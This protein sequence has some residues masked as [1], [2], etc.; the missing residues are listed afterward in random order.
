MEHH[1]K[2]AAEKLGLQL[3][4]YELKPK[5]GKA[6]VSDVAAAHEILGLPVADYLRCCELRLNT[7]KKYP[8][9]KGVIDVYAKVKELKNAPAGREVKKKLE[10]VIT[11]GKSSMSLV[12]VGGGTD[13]EGEE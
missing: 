9:R 1:A 7:S 4:G 10:D 13:D 8:D 6:H 12:A 5:K 2:E 11:T 3:P